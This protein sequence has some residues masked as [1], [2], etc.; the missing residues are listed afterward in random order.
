MIITLL[1]NP[2]LNLEFLCFIN[3]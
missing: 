1:K 2:K 3:K